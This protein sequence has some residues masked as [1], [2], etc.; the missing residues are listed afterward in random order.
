MFTMRCTAR[1]TLAIA[2]AS[3]ALG[4]QAWTA[5]AETFGFS[6]AGNISMQGPITVTTEEGSF[7]CN[8]TLAGSLTSA[9]VSTAAGTRFGSI[10]EA[11][12][13]ACEGATIRLLVPAQLYTWQFLFP[14][15]NRERVVGLLFRIEPIGVL[16]ERLFPIMQ[17][18]FGTTL[19]MLMEVTINEVTANPTFLSNPAL[20]LTQNLNGGRCPATAT[21]SGRLSM[22][23]QRLIYLP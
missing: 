23:S 20:R 11:R 1:V 18:L 9:L 14:L 22:S 2:L 6:P 19:A 3:V 15:E 4:A 8:L 12:A 17:C 16:I 13:A 7:R 21:L 5:M 10:T